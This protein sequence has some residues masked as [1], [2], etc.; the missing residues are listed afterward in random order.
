MYIRQSLKLMTYFGGHQ[1]WYIKYRPSTKF[2]QNFVDLIL[3]S[4]YGNFIIIILYYLAPSSPPVNITVSLI[5]ATAFNSTW[6]IPDEDEHNGILV[7]V[8]IRLVGIDIVDTSTITVPINTTNDTSLQT[9]I[10]SPLEEYVNYS[11]EFAVRNGVGLSPYS[12]R[13][14]LRTAPAGEY[15]IHHIIIQFIHHYTL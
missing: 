8:D 15:M 3:I 5:N 1:N 10:L 13:I 7:S 14:F 11:V 9:T 4:M 6:R 2:R 12:D